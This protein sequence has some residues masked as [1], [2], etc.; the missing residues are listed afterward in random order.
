MVSASVLEKF[1]AMVGGQSKNAV[2]KGLWPAKVVSQSLQL[3][4][5]PT[6]AAVIKADNLFAMPLQPPR[7]E[8]AAVP[9]GIQISRAG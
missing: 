8:I 7:S 2:I 1:F 6:D 9:T 3:R 5:Y 4:I